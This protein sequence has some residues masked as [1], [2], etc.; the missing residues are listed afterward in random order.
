MVLVGAIIVKAIK[1]ILGSRLVVMI[2][3]PM[4]VVAVVV[5][6]KEIVGYQQ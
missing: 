2:F 5:V 3:M 6:A 4:Q 1:F